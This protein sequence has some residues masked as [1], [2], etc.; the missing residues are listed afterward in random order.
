VYVTVSARRSPDR[1]VTPEAVEV[2]VDLAGLGS[3]VVA[4]SIDTLIQIGIAIPILIA[5]VAL[6][7]AET[8][9]IVF[10]SLALFVDFWGYYPLFEGLRNGRTPGK[11]ALRLRVVRTDG[12][13]VDLARVLVRNLVRIV[14]VLPLP[15]LG[16]MSM[17]LTA[18][19]QRLGDLAAGTIV[20]REHPAPLSVPL[21][22]APMTDA[23]HPRQTVD[24]S[25]ITEREYDLVRSFLA[26]REALEPGARAAVAGRLAGNMRPRL[27][28]SGL[29]D[30]P[31]EALL[32]SL[33]RSYRARF[34]PR[35]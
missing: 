14:D 29:A 1:S 8:A 31:D 9:A 28:G 19:S 18:K 27:A 21:Y 17:L 5:A 6:G 15:F 4:G 26:R 3:R 25:A 23:G 10:L 7:L 12:Q 13:P 22:L 34:Q 16:V 30:Q 20:I 35:P 2:A 32:E 24:T 33:A 11:Q